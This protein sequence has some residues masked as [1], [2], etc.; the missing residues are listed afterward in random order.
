M[1]FINPL[2]PRTKRGS[3]LGLQ[4]EGRQFT[5]NGKANVW[6][7]LFAGPLSRTQRALRSKGPG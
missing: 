5:W 4:R 3:G 7:T 2:E 6:Q 1:R